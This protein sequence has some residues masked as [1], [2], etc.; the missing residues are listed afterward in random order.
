MKNILLLTNIYPNN[1]PEYGGTA[2]CHRCLVS[3]MNNLVLY[4]RMGQDGL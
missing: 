3:A 4:Y 1:D 2:V